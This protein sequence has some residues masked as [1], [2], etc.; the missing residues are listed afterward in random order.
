M[1]LYSLQQEAASRKPGEDEDMQEKIKSGLLSI[2]E[3]IQVSDDP[4]LDS[5]TLALNHRDIS[6]LGS[7]ATSFTKAILDYG[8]LNVQMS[9]FQVRAMLRYRGLCQWIFQYRP[10]LL[11]VTRSYVLQKPIPDGKDLNMLCLFVLSFVN[12]RLGYKYLENLVQIVHS[13][14]CNGSRTRSSLHIDLSQIWGNIVEDPI[15]VLP[16]HT[17]VG[18]RSTDEELIPYVTD[19]V[20]DIFAF[21]VL[22][23]SKED[24][25]AMAKTRYW[26]MCLEFLTIV[27][28]DCYGKGLLLLKESWHA[29]LDFGNNI[30]CV[31]VYVCWV[32][33]DMGEY[34]NVSWVKGRY[35]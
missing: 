13:H 24:T 28:Q 18:W 23:K 32:W 7:K 6:E 11:E 17:G 4:S 10:F 34:H 15:C 16:P 12:I 26:R 5:S 21:I 3:D 25:T 9:L 29:F 2:I 20:M 8:S 31:F 33:G 19:R 27:C 30:L 35:D 14:I 1:Q 22:P